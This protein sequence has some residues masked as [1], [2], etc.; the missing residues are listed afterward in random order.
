[1]PVKNSKVAF[2]D[3]REL[4]LELGFSETRE[5]TRVIYRHPVGG[6]LLIRP[7]KGSEK[8]KLTDMLVVR[9][10]LDYNGMVASDDLDRRLQ[11]MPA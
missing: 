10:Q 4:L 1:M 5:K 6:T 11:K 8:V 3:L 2:A 9:Q 7:Y